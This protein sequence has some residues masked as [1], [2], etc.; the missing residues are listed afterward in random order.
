MIDV[1]LDRYLKLMW[2]WLWLIVLTAGLAAAA[3]YL[4][5]RSVTPTYLSVATIMVGEETASPNVNPNDL[6]ISQ[7][8]TG[9]YAELLRRQ[10]VLDATVKALQ[11]PGEWWNLRDRLMVTRVG[12]SQFIELRVEDT[13]PQRAK[14]IADE[15]I[16]QLILQSPTSENLVQME[17]QRQFLKAQL[18][19]L[20]AD[21]KQ[22]EASIA[23]T[24]A[25]V[26]ASFCQ[27]LSEVNL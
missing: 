15:L 19:Q 7:R 14:V 9:S 2:R 10:P 22:A 6:A 18:D 20:Q 4:A 23:E 13:D 24:F 17:Q 11:L 1:D 8:A 5:T 12:D 25:V 16:R 3:S 21:I 27:D 26:V